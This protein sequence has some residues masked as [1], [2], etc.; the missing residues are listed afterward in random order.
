MIILRD[1]LFSKKKERDSSDNDE[2]KKREEDE[3]KAAIAGI[4]AAGILATTKP[5]R[6]TGKV[7]RY[8]NTEKKNVKSILKEGLKAKYSE[9]PNNLTNRVVRD[10][11]MSKKKDLIYTAKKKKRCIWYWCG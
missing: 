2:D 10:V 4:G 1:K 3:N 5:G 7:T 6:L 8:H 11:D 9:D